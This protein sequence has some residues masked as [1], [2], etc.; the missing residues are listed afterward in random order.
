MTDSPQPLSQRGWF[1]QQRHLSRRTLKYTKDPPGVAWECRSLRASSGPSVDPL[2]HMDDLKNRNIFSSQTYIPPR[3]LLE[4]WQCVIEEYSKLKLTCND[5][6]LPAL[7]GL[8]EQVQ[9]RL[10]SQYSAGLWNSFIVRSLLWIANDSYKSTPDKDLG[11]HSRPATYRAPTWSWASVDGSINYGTLDINS[12]GRDE[13]SMER[14][15]RINVKSI[16]ATPLG[17]NPLGKVTGGSLTIEGYVKPLF[18]Q[19]QSSIGAKQVWRYGFGDEA[20]EEPKGRG[21]SKYGPVILDVPSEISSNTQVYYLSV[22]PFCQSMGLALVKCEQ[23]GQG[24]HEGNEL[25]KRVGIVDHVWM[26]LGDKKIIN[27]V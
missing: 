1:L 6:K 8:V 22:F 15:A 18:C 23:S 14:Q 12:W 5:N 3:G 26:S 20:S 9:P 2:E 19:T 27:I 16:S 24:H 13:R 25:Y 17:K 10:G 11:A 7:S 4:S 21:E